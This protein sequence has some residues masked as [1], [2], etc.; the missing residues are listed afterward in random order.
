[1][2]RVAVN[3]GR[4]RQ[5][6]RLLERRKPLVSRDV[7]PD[8]SAVADP[9]LARALARVPIDQ[10]TVLVLR[11]HLDW[12]MDQIAE[13]LD[14]PPGTVKSRLHRGLRRLENLLQESR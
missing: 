14:L 1:M 2:I 8:L 4:N 13:T 3:F 6:R 10:R 12:S 5:R 9:A 7:E 11:F